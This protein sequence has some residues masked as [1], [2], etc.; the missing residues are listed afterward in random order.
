MGKKDL[1]PVQKYR[2]NQKKQ[3]RTKEG[4]AYEK[5]EKDRI[6][7]R[8]EM[9]K[10]VDEDKIHQRVQM[11]LF[12]DFQLEFLAKEEAAGRMTYGMRNEKNQVWSRL[13]QPSV[14]IYATE[15]N[16]KEEKGN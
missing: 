7:A 8:R 4:Q 9:K 14:V 13:F 12:P 11:R 6:K 3:V 5:A 1:N 10:S 15:D 2:K 16:Y